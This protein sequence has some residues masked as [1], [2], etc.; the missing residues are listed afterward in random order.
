MHLIPFGNNGSQ[1]NSRDRVRGPGGP[2]TSV[3][4]GRS[5]SQVKIY[6][7]RRGGTRYRYRT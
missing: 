7:S 5:A 6:C 4:P 2:C 1:T 3:L